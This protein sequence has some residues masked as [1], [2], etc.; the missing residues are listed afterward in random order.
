[1]ELILENV[2]CFSGRHIIPI[3][4]LTVLVGENSSG[5]STFLAAL[6]VVCDSS[7]YPIHPRFNEAPYNLGNFET[8]ATHK[9]RRSGHVADFSLGYTQ[10]SVEDNSIT[11][12]LATYKNDRGQVELWKLK[13][14]GAIGE[15]FLL[16]DESGKKYNVRLKLPSEEDQVAHFSI[17]IKFDDAAIIEVPRFMKNLGTYGLKDPKERSLQDVISNDTMPLMVFLMLATFAP[18]AKALSIAPIR[19]KPKRTYDQFTETFNP[20][21][22]HIPF[23]LARILGEAPASKQEESL[24]SALTRFGAESGLF[25]NVAVRRLG[26]KPGDPFQLMVTV[27]GKPANLLDVGYGVSQA[28]PV[29]VQSILAA[30]ERLLLLQQPEVHLHP[31]AQAALGSFFVDMVVDGEKHLVVETHS[32]YIVDRVRQEVA[33]GKIPPDSVQLLFFEKQGME[34]TIHPITIDE[35]GNVENA[36]PSYREFFLKEEMNILMRGRR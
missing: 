13:G 32:D 29:V 35:L 1:M 30:K 15:V 27:A 9:A 16:L 23:V 8:I 3:K 5:K 34:T 24:I 6:S 21:G 20:E 19:T 17:D 36:P 31:K 18:K 4:P 25:K 7:G 12:L 26:D 33:A 22:D 11:E 14:R 2:R 10:V 28:L